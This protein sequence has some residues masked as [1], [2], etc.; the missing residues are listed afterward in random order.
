M[1]MKIKT[2]VPKPHDR[3]AITKPSWSNCKKYVIFCCYWCCT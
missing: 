3:P 1:F 2:T